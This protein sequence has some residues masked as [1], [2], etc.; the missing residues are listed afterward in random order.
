MEAVMD[1]DDVS[2]WTNGT[3]DQTVLCSFKGVTM[4]T[5]SRGERQLM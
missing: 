1:D 3:A 4:E 5:V 2:V